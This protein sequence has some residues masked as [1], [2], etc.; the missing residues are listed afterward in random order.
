ML[1][2]KE[3]NGE[4]GARRFYPNVLDINAWDQVA[5]GLWLSMYP[6]KYCILE[7]CFLVTSA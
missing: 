5:S 1:W 6:H 4:E 2:K 7:M 3:Y